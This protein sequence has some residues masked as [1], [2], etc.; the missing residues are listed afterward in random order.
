MIENVNQIL[1]I[2]GRDIISNNIGNME[3]ICFMFFIVYRKRIFYYCLYYCLI[4][5][6]YDLDDNNKKS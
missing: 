3:I 5:N 6:K 1:D 4:G 2:I